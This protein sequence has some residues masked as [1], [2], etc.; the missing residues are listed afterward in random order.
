MNKKLQAFCE[1]H[2][3]IV[4]GNS[5][6]GVY[7]NYEIN[8]V[9]NVMNNTAPVAFLISF[10]A[11][12]NDKLNIIQ[13][14]KNEKIKYLQFQADGFGMLFGLNDFTLGAL[15]K[16]FDAILNKIIQIIELNNG[17]GY[18]YCP[19]CGEE[20]TMESKVYKI[21]DAQYKLHIHCVNEL[22]EAIEAENEEF[23]EIP[24][25]YVKGFVGAAIGALVGVI[26]YI[27]FFFLNFIS[28]LSP[29]ISILL[30]AK[31]Y[32]KFGG[33]PNKV[34]VLMVS[35]LTVASLLLTAYALH[36]LAAVG[37]AFE[38]G[39]EMSGAEAMKYMMQD[40]EFAAA[41]R[42]NMIMTVL[43]TLLGAGYEVF[44]LAKSIKRTPKVK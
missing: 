11:S 12:E 2:G 21:N 43:F 37:L 14:L 1:N 13:S 26:S 5:A 31:L 10:Y 6:Y 16:K 29:F 7:K 34:M 22:N 30:G 27:I 25:N 42:A 39:L 19:M 18:E 3:L 17:K 35:L 23:N 24:N 4:K 15:L 44:L 9:Y 20:H 8:L 36:A 28:A 33:K 41:F 38:A 32:Q 40:A